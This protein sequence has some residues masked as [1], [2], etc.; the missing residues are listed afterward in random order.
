LQVDAHDPIESLR[1]RT[2]S[3]QGKVGG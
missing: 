3:L 1:S 2:G